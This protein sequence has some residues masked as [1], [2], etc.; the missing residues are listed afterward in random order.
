MHV[1]DMHGGKGREPGEWLEGEKE[2]SQDDNAVPSLDMN[3]GIDSSKDGE[4][5]VDDRNKNR[6]KV[7]KK[8]RG[9]K[10]G[11]LN[12]SVSPQGQERPRKRTRRD[13]DPFNID[14]FV[15]I[16][17]SGG[18][19]EGNNEVEVGPHLLVHKYTMAKIKLLVRIK[20]RKWHQR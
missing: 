7:F 19:M 11:G 6:R 12:V 20:K 2:V 9:G 4:N 3:I 14:R 5:G 18:T 16:V 17:P 8:K 15:G 13:N 10:K 1:E